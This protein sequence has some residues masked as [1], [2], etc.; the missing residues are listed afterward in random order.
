MADLH[1]IAASL[2]ATLQLAEQASQ[3]YL[4]VVRVYKTDYDNVRF[5]RIWHGWV[6][7]FNGGGRIQDLHWNKLLDR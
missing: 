6:A 4:Q 2:I 5:S 7:V 1:S 3:A